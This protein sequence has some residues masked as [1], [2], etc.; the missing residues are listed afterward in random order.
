[1]NI[2]PKL[3]CPPLIG[4]IE[5]ESTVAANWEAI[6]GSLAGRTTSITRT[7]FKIY[8]FFTFPMNACYNDNETATNLPCR[9]QIW[10]IEDVSA[11]A[12]SSEAIFGPV[13]GRIV[14]YCFC[15]KKTLL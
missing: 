9:V 1:M 15:R 12:V 10:S 6:F 3:L 7:D 8:E 2:I 13:G 11:V 5:E 14:G 4:L